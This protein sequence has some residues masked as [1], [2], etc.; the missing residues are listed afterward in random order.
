MRDL[1]PSPLKFIAF[2]IVIIFTW[3]QIVFAEGATP[4]TPYQTK[5]VQSEIDAA[6]AEQGAVS[7][8]VATDTTIDFLSN[9]PSPLSLV[10]PVPPADPNKT[11]DPDGKLRTELTSDGHAI[12]H[13]YQNENIQDAIG[14]AQSGDTVFVHA[15][16]YHGSITLKQGV[17]LTGE[18]EETVIL[19]GDYV[20]GVSVIRAL[21]NN[22]IEHLTVTGARDGQGQ[23][24][25][26]IKI[27]GDCVDVRDNKILF[28]LSAGVYVYANAAHILIERNL[29]HG[30]PIAIKEP[31][32]G[33]AICYNTITGYETEQ[34][35]RIKGIQY[36]A[37]QGFQLEIQDPQGAY[38]YYMEYSNDYGA[39]WIRAKVQEPS[40]FLEDQL[41]L[42]NI[43]GS[44]VWLDDGSTTSP[45]PLDVNVRWYR[46]VMAESFVSKI[47]I[48]ILNGEAPVVRNNII[49]HQTVQSIWEETATPTSGAAVVEENVLFHNDEKGDVLGQH[50]PPSISPKTGEGWTGGNV[51]ADPQFVDPARGDYTIPET[52]S[53]FGRGAFLPMVLITALSRANQFNVSYHIEPIF[54]QGSVTGFQ[55]FYA[56]GSHEEF[57]NNGTIVLDTTPPQITLPSENIFVNQ[58]DYELI[59]S[60]DEVE[61]RERHDLVDGQNSFTIEASD[62]FGNKTARTVSVT[63][64]RTPPTGTL[65]VNDGD[66]E[67]NSRSV[68]LSVTASDNSPLKDVRFS[69][70]GGNSWTD[71][72]EFAGMK[73]VMLPEG[74]GE[75]EV[76][77]QLR[78]AAGNSVSFSDTIRF[79]TTPVRPVIQFL[80]PSATNDPVYLLRYTV[81]G[82]EH[83]ETWRLQPGEN[84]LMVCSS[85]GSLLA[86][87][88]Y[89][90]TLDQTESSLPA[91]PSPWGLPQDLTSVTA[92]NGLVLK[93]YYGS[94]ITIEKPNE[95]TL[96][97]LEFDGQKNLVGGTLLFTNGDRLLYRNSKPVYRLTQTGEKT[98]YNEDGSVAYRLTPDNK[99]IRFAYQL[100]SSGKILSVLSFEETVVSLYDEK[101]RPV[102]IKKTDGTS[103]FY[104]DGFLTTYADT[105]GNVFHYEVSILHE[106]TQLTGHRSDLISV[107]LAGAAETVPIATILDELE[108]YPAIRTTLEE[109]ISRS[110]EYD[111]AGNMKTVISGKGEILQLANQ[112]P[113]A[114]TNNSGESFQ[115]RNDI[116]QNNEWLSMALTQGDLEQIFDA[117][118]KLSG[119]RLSDGTLLQIKNLALDK[120]CLEDGS[121]L[122]KLFWDTWDQNRLTGFTRTYVDGSKEVYLN[123]SIISR[124]DAAGNVTKFVNDTPGN[125]VTNDGRT[126]RVTEARN[127]QGQTE[128]LTELISI[129]L[130]DGSWVEFQCG[131]PVRYVQKKYVPLDPAEVPVLLDGKF[132]VPSIELSN[133]QLRELTV[134]QNGNIFSGQILFN[135]GTQYLIEDNKIVKQITAT[136]QFVELTGDPLPAFTPQPSVPVEPLTI[137]ETAYRD[138]LVETQLDYFMNGKGIHEGTGLPVDNYIG[139]SDQQSDYSQTTLVGF[140]AEILLSIAT[141]DYGTSKM[142]R[143]EA[144]LKLKNLLGTYREVQRQAGWNGMV[145]FFTIIEKQEPVL[146]PLGNPTGQTRTVYEYKNRFNQVGFGDVLNLSV[147]LASVIGALEDL[148]LENTLLAGYRDQ[149]LTDA[150]AIL[151]DQEAGYAAFYDPVSKR[152]HGAYGLNASSGKWEFINNYYIDR[153]F[154]EFRTGMIWLVSKYP[155]YA[156]ALTNLD[157]AVRPYETQQ[158]DVIDIAA[159]YDGGAFQMFWPLMH[160]DETQYPEFQAALRNFLYAQAEFANTSG[161]PGLLSAGDM[162]LRGYQ[163]K[164]GLP[165]AAETDDA[166]ITHIGSI[167]GMASAFPLA[168]H[169]TLQFFKNLQAQ[170]PGMQTGAGFVDAIQ[171]ETVTQQDP[172][173]GQMVTVQ[174]PVYSDQYYGVDQASLILS[175]LKTSQN[176]FGKYLQKTGAQQAFDNLYRSLKFNLNPITQNNPSVPAFGQNAA[177]LYNGSNATPDGLSSGLVKEP[178]FISTLY[179][180]EL[181]EG[182]VFNYLTPTGNFHHIEI[183]FG[184][185]TN[186]RRMNLQEYFLNPKHTG[187]ATALLGG[188]QLDILN[189]ST[190]QGVFYTPGQG[191]SRSALTIDPE[192]GAVRHLNFQFL[193]PW[194]PVG[195]WANYNNDDLSEYDFLSMPIKLASGTPQNVRLKI[196]FKGMGEVFVTE[197]LTYDWQ[198]VSIPVPKPAGKMYQLAISIQPLDGQP[199]T[200]D[201]YLGP[202]SGVKVRTSNEIDWK[203]LLGKTDAEIRTLIR[204]KIASQDNGAHGY[205][206]QEVLE[207][208]TVDSNGKL[209]SGVL[210]RA[211]GG[212]Q[213]FQNGQLVKWIFKNGRTVLFEDG[214]ATF[215]VDLARGKLET[216]RFY[217][218][219]SF[220]GKIHSFI[221]QDNESKKSFGED[222]QL[223]T[224]VE[225]GY[226]VNYENGGIGSIVTDHGTLTQPEFGNDGSLL[227]G[228]VSL[229]DGSQFDIDQTQIQM[230]DMGGGV[231]LYYDG[232]CIS[233]IETPQNGRT[234]FSYLF[235]AGGNITQVDARFWET[236]QDPQTG[237]NTVVVRNMPFFEYLARP[238]RVIEKSYLLRETSANLLTNSDVGGFYTGNVLPSGEL[239]EGSNNNCISDAAACYQ[240]RYQGASSVSLGM[241]VS[242]PSQV[243]NISNYDF[244]TITLKQDP[245]MDWSQYT[246]V[247]IKT[248]SHGE[249]YSFEIRNPSSEYQTFAFPVAN[250]TGLEGEI[251]V[252]VVRQSDGVAKTG[253][254][255]LKDI[256]YVSLNLLEHPLWEDR[257][258]ISAASIRRLK[259]E[260]N[261]LTSIGSEIASGKPL[262]YA[263]LAGQLDVPTFLRYV[264]STSGA[265]ELVDFN[266][267]DGTQVRLEGQNVNR[268]VLPD[269]TV[270]EYDTT[271]NSVHGTL[272]GP[273][274]DPQ[275]TSEVQY[276]YGALRKITQSDG[277]EYLLSYEFG[278]DGKEITVFKDTRT[279]EERRFKDGKLLNTSN[280]GGLQTQYNYQDGELIGAELTYRNRVLNSTTYTFQNNQTIVT[281]E[282]GTTW[283]YDADG[284][285]LKHLTK[286]GY[287]YEYSDYTQT[288]DPGMTLAPGDFKNV[289]F[290]ATGLKA[291]N[292]IGYEAP[293]GSQILFDYKSEGKG[294]IRLASGDH[295]VN[296]VLDAEQKIQSGQVQFADGLVIEIENYIPVRGRVANGTLFDI[297]LPE[298]E[299]YEILQS[300]SGTYTGFRLKIGELF[301]TYDPLG[302]LVKAESENGITHSFNYTTNAQ[303]VI[304]GYTHL[305]KDQIAFNGVPFPKEVSLTAGTSQKLLD[306]AGKEIAVHERDGFLVGVYRATAD[307]WDIYSGSFASEGDRLGLKHFL[308][309]IKA[310][311][312]VA[313]VVSDASFS[314]ID[315]ETLAL[316]EGLGAVNVRQAASNN[317]KW[318]FFGNETLDQGQGYEKLGA[319]SFSTVTETTNTVVLS[320]GDIPRFENT[321]MLLSMPSEIEQSFS[322]FLEKYET[323]KAPQDMQSVTVYNDQADIVYTRR[324][325]GMGSYYEFG[326]VRETYD[327]DGNLIVLHEYECPLDGCRNASDPVLK[328]I[329]LVKAR[330][331]F[332]AE[333]VRLEQQIEQTKFDALYRLA[334]QDEVARAQIKENVD[335]GVGQINGQ[336]SSLESQRFQRVKE[337]HQ[338][339][340]WKSCSERTVEVPGVQSAINQWASQRAELIRT[341]E[342]QLAAIPGAIAAKKAEIEQATAEKQQELVQKKQEFLLDVLHQEMDPIITDFYRNVLGRDP[343]KQEFEQWVDRFK[344]A[345]RLDIHVLRDELQ[346]SSE[347]ILREDQKAAMVQSVR[348]FLENYLVA[349]P[350]IK[351]Q[352]LQTLQ[353]NSSEVVALDAEDVSKVLEWLESR[354]L[355]FGQSAFLSLQEMLRSKGIEVPVEI[356]G[357]EAIL[358]DILS[359]V[360]NRFTE[361]DLLISMFALDRTASIHGKDFASV[362]FTY[363]DL[364]SMYQTSCGLSAQSCGLR[365]IAH[366]GEDHFVV[367]KQVT[368]TEVTYEE[369]GKGTDGEDVTVTKE[370]F[371][372]VWTARDQ[373]GYLIVSEEQAILAK[374]LSDQEAMKIRGAFWF[375]FF[376]VAAVFLTVASM[377]VSVFSPTLGK[378]LGYAA[379]VAGIIGIIAGLGGFIVQG[380]KAVFSSIAQQGFFSTIKQGFASIGKILFES[381][382]SVGRFI[383]NGFAFLKDGFTGG[384]NGLGSGIIQMKDFLLEGAGKEILNASHQ[385]I[386][387]E[388]TFTQMAVRGLIAST[389]NFSVSKGLEGL[390]LDPALARLGGAFVGGG[391]FG[392]GACGSDFLKSGLQMFVLQGVSEMGAKIGLSPPIT[393]ALSLVGSTALGRLFN[394]NFSLNTFIPEIA[395]TLV[396]KL[397]LGGMELIGRSMGLDSRITQ[398]LGLPI[399]SIVGNITARFS[400]TVMGYRDDGTPIY[401]TSPYD[402]GSLWDSIKNSLSHGI[403]QVGFEFSGATTNPIFGSLLSGDIL[404]SIGNILGKEG[405]FNGILNILKETILA[406]FNAINNIV[407]TALQGLRDF[408]DLIREKGLVGALE[409]FAAS[410]FSRN[411]LEKILSLGGISNILNSTI[412]NLTTLINGQ[413]AQEQKIDASTSLYYDLL[414]NFIGKKENGVTQLGTFGVDSSGKWALLAGTVMAALAGGIIFSG[415]VSNGQLRHM[416]L[417]GPDGMI[418]EGNSEQSGGAIV[419]RGPED[420]PQ[421]S[422]AGSFWSGIFNV[423]ALGLQFLFQ[424]GI[425]KKV[426]VRVQVNNSGTAADTRTSALYVLT[427]GVNNPETSIA[428]PPDYI[429]NLSSDLVAKNNST[430]LPSDILTTPVYLK[431][432]DGNIVDV[433]KDILSWALESQLPDIQLFLVS[434]IRGILGAAFALRLKDISRPVIGMGFSG[435][436]LP[437]L[438]TVTQTHYCF[439]TLVGIGAATMSLAK[440]AIDAILKSVDLIFTKTVDGLG[441]LLKKIGVGYILDPITQFLDHGLI[442]PAMDLLI[443]AVSMITKNVP[444]TLQLPSLAGTGVEMLVNVYGTNDIL[445]K[446]GIAGY[447]QELAGFTIE[448][449]VYPNGKP[450]KQLFN[451]EIKGCGHS[452]YFTRDD[453]SLNIPVVND[454]VTALLQNAASIEKLRDFLATDS[455]VQPQGNGYYVVD[456]G[457]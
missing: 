202:L 424:S 413:Q 275:S 7:S 274:H 196:E 314:Q 226:F 17:N 262:V 40:G 362:K 150:N 118:G 396:S 114:F 2:L 338:V 353:L 416:T 361:G 204:Q 20:S 171:M 402:V 73:V 321:P 161:L 39:S 200:G 117:Q 68:V 62:I 218:D 151:T 327:K 451:I 132:F 60:V 343:S 376:F 395:P 264:Q 247:R 341:G 162:P 260:S 16:T 103:I 191:L 170:F 19:H 42:A 316:L 155:Q 70:D 11:Y 312:S 133:A 297:Q 15:G 360:I 37:G 423:A 251:T 220:S 383:Q 38:S 440:D 167:Y 109:E 380:V 84:Q 58:S 364:C 399:S 374:K 255:L 113:V 192:I 296:L 78:D 448:G 57:Y 213:Y 351:T 387:H 207:N 293:D 441:D 41:V 214:L 12:R 281:D 294:E 28:N 411:T 456:L 317:S 330:Q 301:F 342:E 22:H 286:D 47:G 356:L 415:D 32:S 263:Q 331:N 31:K 179:D 422:N 83:Q 418:L 324:L 105:T 112:L 123:S 309:E 452:N 382:R 121:I 184:S 230:V 35:T 271:Q 248:A 333:A 212:I 363:D 231:K 110:I 140:W 79:T 254:L 326:K 215:V 366:I 195:I 417:S 55:I 257:L 348:T 50:L 56:E 93:Y 52:S 438:E 345:E 449:Q 427:N 159:P 177:P 302:R 373:S 457:I 198:Y 304:T 128:Q 285:L 154:N 153:V 107:T 95:Y 228:H 164:I 379:L 261:Q 126:Y 253:T 96:F 144:F 71:W 21:G 454:F 1:L 27:E 303:G 135:D 149:I 439:E 235:D 431:Q 136:G 401:V 101:G 442:D 358:I 390:G 131:K 46:V 86:F 141:G 280:A 34:Y 5:P 108:S 334:W 173:T 25:A 36:V 347:K 120:I 283:F 350:E 306:S 219:Q 322:R 59:Y 127:A 80:S 319:D 116:Q 175:L 66:E 206:N 295:G 13:V 385:V 18:S 335:G 434:Q 412:R 397:T 227:K 371:L 160:V 97:S 85:L 455:R 197:P 156:D 203:L 339:F 270:N 332:E 325:D 242:H 186:P 298:A 320:P 421:N 245:S 82:V 4:Y 450:T 208:F 453:P 3:N 193:S 336:I 138:Q 221:V 405:L 394:G 89:K 92:A 392:I 115:F 445:V 256:S 225:E 237:Q 268:I 344:Q 329:T 168:P 393:D 315:Q 9:P 137:E 403:Q 407:Q 51:L 352:M 67:T 446:T 241:Y 426:D 284:K 299:R 428:V 223:Q 269:G 273:T 277:R 433:S 435:G 288:P 217:Y 185:E 98:V 48:E 323:L 278:A 236:V 272:Q 49:A 443:E 125:I 81:N 246:V 30:N 291:V 14:Q 10:P 176:Y 211:D 172:Q 88:D 147:S 437:L 258:G 367:I 250:K 157:V 165:S 174:R 244:L 26:A 310:G 429:R 419:I 33:N 190:S 205:S 45:G 282:R 378:I 53:A 189:S 292:L 420:D 76:F 65:Q 259:I 106:G 425:L 134:D 233:A 404:S 178:A 146:D 300:E 377:V 369:T 234:E 243:N 384:F 414:G 201:L 102:W 447:R 163:G 210:K 279:G 61:K 158:G 357:K 409:S 130:A 308:S 224:L 386:G 194:K 119:I 388:F 389:L 187:S 370:Q 266:R 354:D 91:M 267:F 122:T 313:A 391:F 104:Q 54:E 240:F 232:R 100:D 145:A 8:Q 400:G 368:D 249:M 239:T 166:L 188:L 430:I 77:C 398:L 222:G 183:E 444:S 408:N 372:K 23:I 276:S 365:V 182:R 381:V 6:S 406:P 252:E 169:Y 180:P 148:S 305:E 24:A 139:P 290:T 87:A 318:S 129:Q 289:V 64:D 90:V 265:N 307:Q 124:T 337:C 209:V 199:V 44:S 181:G 375:I 349:T 216:G 238:E 432:F 355:H 340:F 359:G 111:P 94:L 143:E 72:E 311:D 287:L 99:K 74:E 410:I 29:F 75:K 69:L 328:K 229:L 63:L 152:F 436:F 346:N 142:S 43:T